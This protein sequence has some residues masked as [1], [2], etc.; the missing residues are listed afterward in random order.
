MSPRLSYPVML[1]SAV[2]LGAP[3]IRADDVRFATTLPD[4]SLAD[5]AG[6]VWDRD[7]VLRH[8]VVLVVTAPTWSQADAQQ[9]WS[10]HLSRERGGDPGLVLFI[11][12]MSQSA[13]E[14]W[15]ES[16]MESAYEPGSPLIPLL[17]RDGSLRKAVGV[18]EDE[19]VILAYDSRGRLRYGSSGEPSGESARRAWSALDR[20]AIRPR[21]D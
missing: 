13:I 12:D 15:A 21:G 20:D 6:K 2:A 16:E 17:D 8:G 11:E 1:I 14:S 3:A 10:E 4:F 9:E 18:A 5:P 7:E 19:T